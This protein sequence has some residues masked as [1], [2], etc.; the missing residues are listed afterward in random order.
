MQKCRRI[1]AT[2]LIF[3]AALFKIVP[4]LEDT[5]EKISA[6]KKI[7]TKNNLTTWNL[8]IYSVFISTRSENIYYQYIYCLPLNC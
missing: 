8:Y 5:H 1:V 6:D 3:I 4:K 2:S 7:A